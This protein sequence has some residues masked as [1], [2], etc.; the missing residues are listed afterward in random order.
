V[1]LPPRPERPSAQFEGR[2]PEEA[3]RLA[4]REYGHEA[5]LRCWKIRS[6]GVLGFFAREAFV[7][8]VTPPPGAI[9]AVKAPRPVKEAK[10]P[11]VIAPGPAGPTIAA[12]PTLPASA[13]TSLS[14]L[15][16]GTSDQVTL[17]ADRVPAAV[18]SEVLAEAQAAV[19]GPDALV[20][21]SHSLAVADRPA[22]AGAEWAHELTDT[23]VRLGVP[24]T[25]RA[26]SVEGSL[27][28]LA[29]ALDAL[30]RPDPVPDV[31][32]SVIVVVGGLRDA[33]TAASTVAVKLGLAPSDLM[34]AEPT[35]IDRQRLARRR[36]SNKV[37][38]LVVEAT[39]RSRRL[40]AVAS[41]MEKVRP[42]YVVGAVPATA[43]RS[44]VELWRVQ[45]GHLDTLALSRLADTATPGELM[46]L[47]PIGYLDGEE[48]STL[49]WVSIL[50]GSKNAVQP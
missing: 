30:P 45:L 15:V 34:H 11:P 4:R 29:D 20:V 47:L 17:G 6:G 38:V 10:K 8:G 3:V 33:R 49:R 37:T 40:A 9:N 42:D 36:S 44:D 25:F 7:A 28:S 46:G 32:G 13:G 19:G 1:K 14:E 26:N 48:A 21:A 27:D 39:L 24:T 35:D 43:K 50:L 5:S 18:F 12:E 2:T 16:E 22:G 41:W 23:L 31:G